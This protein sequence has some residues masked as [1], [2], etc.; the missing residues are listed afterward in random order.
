[1][2]R[3]NIPTLLWRRLVKELRKRGAGTRESGAF[4]LGTPGTGRV[5]RFI[6]YDDLDDK[7]LETGIITVHAAGFVRLWDIC[8]R[9]NLKVLADVHTHPSSWTGQS[10]PDRTHPMVAQPGHIALILPNY[11][12]RTTRPLAG[13]SVYEYLGD[14][15]WQNW[16]AKSGPVQITLL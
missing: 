16:P 7:A 6:C 9:E 3:I 8:K 13:A 5:S 11:A 15:E 10:E 1:M 4:L 12:K 2:N 14:H